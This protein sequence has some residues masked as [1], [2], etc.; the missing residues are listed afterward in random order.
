LS[1]SPSTLISIITPTYNRASFLPAM[2]QSVQAQTFQ[3][4]ELWIVDDG[5]TDRTRELVESFALKDS[6]IHYLHKINGGQGS[7]RNL[8]IT[9]SGGAFIAFLD[10]DD[11]WLPEKLEK[12][13]KILGEN[14][15]FDFCYTADI[16]RLIFPEPSKNHRDRTVR[17]QD[18]EHLPEKKRAGLPTSVPSSH[19]YRR[20]VF[21]NVGLF[22]ENPELKGLE[23]ND[24]SLRGHLLK[25][26]YLDEPL[27]IY[28]IHADQITQSG[29][30]SERYEKALAYILKKNIELL[31]SF[32]EALSFRLGQLAHICLLRGDSAKARDYLN[33]GKES[34]QAGRSRT[35]KVLLKSSW[36][37]TFLYRW[38]DAVRRRL[39]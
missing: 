30:K 7:A 8:G 16:E 9:R 6:R 21:Q 15:G 18:S 4:W 39:P 14:A 29:Y 35:L 24:W 19:L 27:T 31:K 11:L 23:D 13:I 1:K 25:G 2:V 33:Q 37:P 3:E 26:F 10:S 5:S 22:D 38:L 17:V 36:L 32:P 28:Q 12:Q 20:E 34:Q